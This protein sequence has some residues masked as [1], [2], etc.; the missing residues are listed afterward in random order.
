MLERM[1]NSI[2]AKT[3][4]LEQQLLSRLHK[5]CGAII[6]G[7]RKLKSAHLES[8]SSQVIEKKTQNLR[9]K[10][11]MSLN[12]QLATS[13]L[14]DLYSQILKLKNDARALLDANI[15]DLKNETKKDVIE[16]PRMELNEISV[17]RPSVSISTSKMLES[18]SH[19]TSEQSYRK[20]A[21]VKHSK[22]S[23]VEEAR[24]A[25]EESDA[26]LKSLL[27]NINKNKEK[28]LSITELHAL[29]E[30]KRAPNNKA[31][32]KLLDIIFEQNKFPAKLEEKVLALEAECKAIEQSVKAVRFT[33]ET[34]NQY[35]DVNFNLVTLKS[36]VNSIS[37][38]S[39]NLLEQVM[40]KDY[41]NQL[42]QNKPTN[43]K[44]AVTQ[45]NK[46]IA[47]SIERA[48]KIISTIKA[49]PL[50]SHLQ[51][52]VAVEA[53]KKPIA[54]SISQ[55]VMTFFNRGSNKVHPGAESKESVRKNNFMEITDGNKKKSP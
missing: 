6:D 21:T 5:Q 22:L 25:I 27:I 51:Q 20:Q 38:A 42:A 44:S 35:N 33:Q 28:M 31:A 17:Q 32:V 47:N 23:D 34:M 1:I 45:R 3:A 12:Q 30:D 36:A 10:I 24:G 52:A 8:E 37:S 41:L 54:P 48:Y 16:V 46:F 15:V 50:M 43:V 26:A 55:K 49:M 19:S 40:T 2:D 7:M 18:L 53:V 14:T 11:D 4:E 39:M 9:S 13:N 29:A